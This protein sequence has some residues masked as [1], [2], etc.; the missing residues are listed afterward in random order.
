MFSITLQ[1]A[2]K[3]SSFRHVCM[4]SR[5][6]KKA[7][8]TQIAHRG[9]PIQHLEAPKAVANQGDRSDYLLLHD[10]TLDIL[11]YRFI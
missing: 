6:Y 3:L 5:G 8:H 4:F 9:F 2:Q 10:S 7:M 1:F 11:Q